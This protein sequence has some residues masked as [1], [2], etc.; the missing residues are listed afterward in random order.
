MSCE[1]SCLEIQIPCCKSPT[2]QA[3]LTAN[4]TY[5]FILKIVGKNK[6]YIKQITTAATGA[7]TID[8]SIMPEGFFGYGYIEIEARTGVGFAQMQPFL[9][10]SLSYNCLLLEIIDIVE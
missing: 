4:T 6:Q 2:I 9:K 3:G 1:K 5:Q 10:D 8:K 7:F